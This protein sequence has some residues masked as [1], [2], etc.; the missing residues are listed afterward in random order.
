MA[1]CFGLTRTLRRCRRAVSE[2][3]L[4]CGDH[5]R[6]P[7]AWLAF[8]VFTVGGGTASLYSV[9]LSSSPRATVD[10]RPTTLR[11]PVFEEQTVRLG[12]NI[13]SRFGGRDIPARDSPG[14][15]GKFIV[16]YD[17]ADEAFQTYIGLP[18]LVQVVALRYGDYLK[19]VNLAAWKHVTQQPRAEAP[20]AY[21]NAAVRIDSQTVLVW[22]AN[23]GAFYDRVAAMAALQNINIYRELL[24]LGHAIESKDVEKVTF[25]CEG[26]H[27]GKRPD[28]PENI[29]L[30]VDSTVIPIAF[31]ST[32]TRQLENV[33]ISI[34][35]EALNIR[36][37]KTVSI[38]VVVLPYQEIAPAPP[39]T[40]SGDRRGPA[41]FRDVELRGC[42]IELSLSA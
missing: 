25:W 18:D 38:G 19:S 2:G 10:V 28:Q 37:D 12:D 30:I 23:E 36:R 16:Y 7:L 27:G 11:I 33:H 6:Q 40:W 31:S 39:P 24:R 3:A 5:S 29:E 26:L 15:P 32:A 14:G 8:A 13:Y 34:P 1:R 42:E 21:D 41:H 4:L 17:K 9:V 22:K 20:P 35:R